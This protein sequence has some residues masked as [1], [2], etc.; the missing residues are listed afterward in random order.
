MLA[1]DLKVEERKR[2]AAARAEDARQRRAAAADRFAA[3]RTALEEAIKHKGVL[4]LERE[5]AAHAKRTRAMTASIE[6]VR[7]R[8]I[9]SAPISAHGLPPASPR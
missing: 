1:A 2:D 6:K 3:N 4:E 7:A 5:Q 8:P 9:S